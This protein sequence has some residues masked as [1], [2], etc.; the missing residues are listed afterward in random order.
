MVNGV[1]DVT[2]FYHR[3]WSQPEGMAKADQF[4]VTAEQ[5][6]YGEYIYYAQTFSMDAKGNLTLKYYVSNDGSF[7]FA[8][9]R[10]I[11]GAAS[12]EWTDFI[13]GKGALDGKGAK[14]RSF[15][16]DELRIY[17]KV[18]SAEEVALVTHSRPSGEK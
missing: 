8:Y 7:Y 17:D 11:S 1:D 6:T 4:N 18:L 13:I 15:E 16:F 9:E 10:T 5:Y 14:G 2:R 12:L 3:F